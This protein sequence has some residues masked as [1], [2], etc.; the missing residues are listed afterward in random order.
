MSDETWGGAAL[1]TTDRLILRPF[2]IDD[3][4][5]YQAMGDDPLVM[6]YLGG[7]WSHARTEAAARGANQSLVEHGYGMLAVERRDDGRFLGIAGLSVEQWYPDDLQVGWRFLP[8]FWGQ[9]Y[10]TEAATAWLDHGFGPLGRERIISMAD[11]PNLRSIAVMRRLGMSLDHEAR[12]R[13]GDEEFDASIYV[14]TRAAWLAQRRA[15]D[16][17]PLTL[18]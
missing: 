5:P 13:D 6:Q 11:T 1:L 9:G 12:L 4:P 14:M 7:L 18:F 3:L 16:S 15:G 17:S 10:A 8:Q 2:R